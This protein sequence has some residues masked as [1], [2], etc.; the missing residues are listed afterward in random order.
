MNESVT[1]F[2]PEGWGD[3]KVDLTQP[4]V[5]LGP[6]SNPASKILVPGFFDQHIHGAYGADFMSSPTGDLSVMLNRLAEDGYEGLLATTVTASL[7]ETKMALANLPNHPMVAGVHLEGPFISPVYP[8]AQPPE[9][10]LEP[11]AADSPWWEL[12]DDPRVRMV[13]L[14]P[15]RPGALDVVAKL[16]RRGVTVSA[17]HTNATAVELATAVQEGLSSATHTYNAMRPLHH[18]EPGTVGAVLTTDTVSAE[19]IYDR[20]HVSKQAA[21]VLLRCKPS[22][23]VIAVSDCTMAKGLAPG[24]Q[25]SMWGHDVVV[26]ETDVRLA[27]NGALAGSCSTLLDC[28]RYLAADFEVETAARLCCVNPRQAGTTPKKWLLFD[29][30]L[31]ILTQIT[32]ERPQ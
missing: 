4:A 5:V 22:E 21:E 17:G 7:D 25:L 23:R 28:F 16:A 26:G 2:G 19:L 1:C 12:L 9:S 14:A 32:S 10:I 20:H 18:R 6:A 11:P 15:E 24:S 29:K 31:E 3:Y 8:G 27:S 13:T 30:N